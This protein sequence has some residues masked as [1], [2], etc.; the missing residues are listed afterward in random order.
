LQPRKK[1]DAQD[2]DLQAK[3][4][5]LFLESLPRPKIG[6]WANQ[7]LQ[8]F[9]MAGSHGEEF[10]EAK[11]RGGRTESAGADESTATPP[12][13]AGGRFMKLKDHCCRPRT[14]PAAALELS[15]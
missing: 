13:R 10:A 11:V 2:V 8:A 9:A 5:L 15:R 7:S 6:W 14:L 3:A 1:Q 4:R 12:R